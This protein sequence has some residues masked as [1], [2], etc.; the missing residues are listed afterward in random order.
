MSAVWREGCLKCGWLQGL[1]HVQLTCGVP[2]TYLGPLLPQHSLCLDSTHL[3]QGLLHACPISGANPQEEAGG[4]PGYPSPC[5]G[6]LRKTPWHFPRGN[7]ADFVCVCTHARAHTNWW[8]VCVQEQCGILHLCTQPAN[9]PA[10]EGYVYL[11]VAPCHNTLPRVGAPLLAPLSPS[12][13]HVLP[14]HLSWELACPLHAKQFCY[15]V[16]CKIF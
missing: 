6:K 9:M 4:V 5:T 2:G 1:D 15:V 3:G 16:R 14:P 7:K 13:P 10:G 11:T 12:T 8:F